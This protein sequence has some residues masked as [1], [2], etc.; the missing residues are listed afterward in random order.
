MKATW[1]KMRI[2]TLICLAFFGIAT[3]LA[4]G[5]SEKASAPTYS[6]D[7]APIL[8]ARCVSCHRPGEIGPMPLTSFQQVRP[9]AKAIREAVVEGKMPPWHADPTIGRFS[10][11]R[12]LSD[13]Q[14]RTLLQWVNSGAPEGDPNDVPPPARFTEGWNIGKPDVEIPIPKPFE[15][16]A[17]GVVD[18]QYMTTPTHFTE[19]QWI[20]A[21]EV[22]PGDRSVVHH[23][24]AFVLPP[25]GQ[26]A[27]G[28]GEERRRYGVSCP[29][30]RP[31]PE[32]AQRY[33]ER[34]KQGLEPRDFG[35]QLVGWAPGL[36]GFVLPPGSAKRIP[37]G[38]RIMF[39]LHYT[40]SGK[41]AVDRDT[42]IGLT[43]AREP[44]TRRAITIGIMNQQLLLP[45]GE[46]NYEAT[47]CYTF[48]RDVTL[49]EFMPHMHLRGK[50]FT[51]RVTFPDGRTET[52]L[53][54]PR[55][56][57]SWQ[58]T[59]RLAEPLKLPKGS[60][61]DCLAHFDNSARNKYNPDPTQEVRW[62]D[63][64]WEE[65]LIGWVSFLVD[66]ASASSVT[67]SN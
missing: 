31:A 48:S 63:Q 15:V 52:I 3:W 25:E 29:E 10:N 13:D 30:A 61:I 14:I 8:N 9:Y 62:G 4:A 22:R 1:G 17:E 5:P 35:F 64:T 20:V 40:P 36:L 53:H 19:D 37:A 59:Y 50:D 38:S 28:A 18:Y 21:A 47:S 43:F 26:P 58:T 39:Q 23:V 11:D 6:R 16:P 54:V 60:R 49:L 65:M 66:E 44:I 12:R 33:R 7:V 56:D 24:I 42:R 32:A 67:G 51:Y 57:F 55:Y 27:L 2:A 41:A 45:P 34:L 46:P